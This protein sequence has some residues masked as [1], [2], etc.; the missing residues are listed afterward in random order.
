LWTGGFSLSPRAETVGGAQRAL[1]L[2]A[3]ATRD[4]AACSADGTTT[5]TRL[6]G[7]RRTTYLHVS[8]A[9]LATNRGGGRVERLRTASLALLRDWLQT[10]PANLACLCR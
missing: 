9:D 5:P 7:S 2:A 3:F 8:L 6:N 4:P 1:D 10:S